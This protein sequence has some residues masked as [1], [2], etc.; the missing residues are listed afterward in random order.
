LYR[1]RGRYQLAIDILRTALAL[2]K[3]HEDFSGCALTMFQ[4]A[5]N[6]TELGSFPRLRHGIDSR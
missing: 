4:I 3:M 2:Q 6:Y 1:R 5:E